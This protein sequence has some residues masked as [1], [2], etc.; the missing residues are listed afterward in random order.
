MPRWRLKLVSGL[1]L[2]SAVGTASA[3]DLPGPP[4][5]YPPPTAPAVYAPAPP[6]FSWS[7]FYFGSAFGGGW[8][9]GSGTITATTGPTASF[10]LSGSGFVGGVDVGGLW[11]FGAAVAG[12]EAD[13]QGTSVSGS[14]STAT[15]AATQVSATESTPY[16]GTVRGRLGYAFDR[17][18]LYAT[19]GGVFGKNN[20]SG[21]AAGPAASPLFTSSASFTTWTAG[22]GIEAAVWGPLSAKIEYLYIGTPSTLPSIPNPPVTGASLSSARMNVVRV[23]LNYHF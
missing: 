13:F 18:L 8:A 11:Q 1:I 5:A 19:A 14:L 10:S 4:P 17:I 16:F 15:T 3:A 12:V 6:P 22:A 23:G 7:G 9:S 2:A 21:F 20:L